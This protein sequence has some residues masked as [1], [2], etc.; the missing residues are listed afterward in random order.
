MVI[1]GLA[2]YF[3]FA[4][5]LLVGYAIVMAIWRDMHSWIYIQITHIYMYIRL[6]ALFYL[7]FFRSSE[8]TENDNLLVVGFMILQYIYIMLFVYWW[9]SNGR[10]IF[11]LPIKCAILYTFFWL[12]QPRMLHWMLPLRCCIRIRVHV[13]VVSDVLNVG[14]GL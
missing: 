4:S 2:N 3:H 8:W 13:H 14:D 11:N 12:L 9:Y 1:V 6:S 10:T 5:S 7:F